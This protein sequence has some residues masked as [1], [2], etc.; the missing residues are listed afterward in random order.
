ME[1]IPLYLRFSPDLS[2]LSYHTEAQIIRPCEQPTSAGQ[3]VLVIL[4]HRSLTSSKDVFGRPS[5]LVSK[6]SNRL[7]ARFKAHV[8]NIRWTNSSVKYSTSYM[9]TVAFNVR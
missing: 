4:A 5:K 2:N 8:I 9:D 7:M 6:V 3:V 1:R